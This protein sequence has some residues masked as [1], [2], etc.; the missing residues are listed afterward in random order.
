MENLT[1][2]MRA[3]GLTMKQTAEIAGVDKSVIV[4]VCGQ[5]Y[6]EWERKEAEIIA[7]TGSHLIDKIANRETDIELLA[8]SDGKY[9]WDSRDIYYY[10]NYGMPL[11]SDFVAAVM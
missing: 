3:N 10:E 6:Y 8:Y 5:N 7:A 4:K 11:N 2:V 9:I 1:S